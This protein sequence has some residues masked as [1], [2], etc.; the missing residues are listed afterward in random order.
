M[1]IVTQNKLKALEVDRNYIAKC[2]LKI[3]PLMT[4]KKLG[5]ITT[6]MNVKRASGI[7]GIT[8]HG[9]FKTVIAAV[10]A[11]YCKMG[12]ESL[13]RAELSRNTMMRSAGRSTV[14][15]EYNK[16]IEHLRIAAQNFRE[17]LK[18]EKH[19]PLDSDGI[20]EQLKHIEG[21]RASL[22]DDRR[23]ALQN[24]AAPVPA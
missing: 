22:L 11:G 1:I 14:N 24:A 16:V 3:H 15:T 18:Y 6:L 9:D 7:T 4:D 20:R 23:A 17:A 21:I 19:T 12:F 2:G 10:A 8:E 5:Q 13:S